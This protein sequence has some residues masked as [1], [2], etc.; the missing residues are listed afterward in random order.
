MATLQITQL[1]STAG[2]NQ[3]QRAT[4]QSLGLGRI[5]AAVERTD[6]PAVQGMIRVVAHLI[7]VRSAGKR[8]GSDG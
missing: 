5:G 4:L 3:R 7:D 8:K 1:R 6:G 2:T